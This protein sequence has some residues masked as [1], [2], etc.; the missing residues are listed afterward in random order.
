MSPD[1]KVG[2]SSRL[3]LL[4]GGNACH[5]NQRHEHDRYNVRASGIGAS[6]CRRSHRLFGD[7]CNPDPGRAAQTYPL[8]FGM[9]ALMPRISTAYDD[10]G[11]M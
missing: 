9:S 7:G 10:F 6:R 2:R 5:G 1:N 3:S 8:A 4:C 11:W